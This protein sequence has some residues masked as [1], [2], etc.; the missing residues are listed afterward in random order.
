MKT[1]RVRFAVE[2]GFE[3]DD[4]YDYPLYS[5]DGADVFAV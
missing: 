3:T 1:A 4:C 5:I 2:D